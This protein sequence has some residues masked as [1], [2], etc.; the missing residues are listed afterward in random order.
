MNRFLFFLCW[1][2]FIGYGV[3]Q[4]QESSVQVYDGR[5]IKVGDIIQ[6]GHSP[7]NQYH[8]IRDKQKYGYV[9]YNKDIAFSKLEVLDIN[10]T[11]KF[12][13]SSMK[14]TVLHVKE[15]SS[16]KDLYIDI[17]QA[18]EKGEIIAESAQRLFPN[19]KFLSDDLLLALTHRVN[20]FPVTDEDILFLIKLRDNDLYKKCK[21]NEFEFN[22]VKAEYS[23]QLEDMI[24][25]FDFTRIFYINNQIALDKYDFSKNGYPINYIEPEGIGFSK[26][27]SYFF[28]FTN[29]KG[30]QFIPVT[31]EYGKEVNKRRE[32]RSSY[33]SSVAYGRFYFKVLDQM[34]KIEKSLIFNRE[35]IYRKVL[36]GANLMGIEVY[37]FKHCDY[38]FIGSIK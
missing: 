32:G 24:N 12:Y 27:G 30:F 26:Y 36:I 3:V 38:N 2:L 5:I 18:I 19:A 9:E 28:D 37:D 23:K 4:A 17:N 31:L 16:S 25:N 11:D 20:K 7:Y 22:A 29:Y 8:F 21:A 1:F 14:E 34:M 6:A 10:K 35:L 13:G 15:V 33:I